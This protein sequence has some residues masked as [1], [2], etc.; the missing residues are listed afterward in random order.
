MR[1]WWWLPVRRI[2]LYSYCLRLLVRK[3]ES[4]VASTFG[5]LSNRGI[6]NTVKLDVK[7]AVCISI[8]IVFIYYS[9]LV[10]VSTME[11]NNIICKEY[12]KKLGDV[13]G[14]SAMRKLHFKVQL[15]WYKSKLQDF[16]YLKKHNGNFDAVVANIVEEFDHL[17]SRPIYS[18]TAYPKPYPTGS[19]SMGTVWRSLLRFCH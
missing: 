5:M 18:S 12:N 17:V 13:S 15:D 7:T 8:F 6:R 19:E 10:V 1:Q 3:G 2:S 4:L 9:D 14:D 11:Y 16:I